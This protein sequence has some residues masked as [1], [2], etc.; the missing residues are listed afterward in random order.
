MKQVIV[1]NGELGLPPGKLAGQVAHAAVTGALA[2][3]D[4]VR[5]AWDAEGMT[6]IVLVGRDAQHLTL[7]HACALGLGVKPT[8]IIKDAG[9]TL[10]PPGT[11]TCM[12][13][14]PALD[15]DIDRVTG[16]LPLL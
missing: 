4:E 9:R 1:V 10:I 2:A 14:G 8:G 13:I 7:I 6:K 16:S 11:L 5:E 3:K 15:K 12:F